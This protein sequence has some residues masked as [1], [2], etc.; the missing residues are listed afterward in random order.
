MD[1]SLPEPFGICPDTM[2]PGICPYRDPEMATAE[3]RAFLMDRGQVDGKRTPHVVHVRL[4]P[5]E[6]DIDVPRFK[7]KN[8]AMLLDTLGFRQST[9]IAA[10]GRRLLTHDAQLFP[11]QVILVRAVMS[12]G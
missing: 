7:A 10:C 3:G 1:C 4:Q 11:E 2:C 8:V 6:I 12:R 5:E 9:A